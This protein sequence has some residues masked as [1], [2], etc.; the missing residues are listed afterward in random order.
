MVAEWLR[1][2]EYVPAA[3]ETAVRRGEARPVL[4]LF[5]EDEAGT[6]L[7]QVARVHGLTA[8]ATVGPVDGDGR[9]AGRGA[10]GRGKNSH[11]SRWWGL[12]DCRASVGAW[13]PEVRRAG[14]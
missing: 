11:G 7:A 8:L 4:A 9:R 12:R 14:A 10:R 6:V 5:T 3:L 13:V 2:P 1:Q